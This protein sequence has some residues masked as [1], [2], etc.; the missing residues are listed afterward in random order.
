MQSREAQPG[1]HGWAPE[2]PMNA[3]IVYKSMYICTGWGGWLGK[4][5]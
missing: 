5:I 2:V 1:V 3:L 4:D